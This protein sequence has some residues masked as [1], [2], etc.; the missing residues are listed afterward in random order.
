M[1]QFRLKAAELTLHTQILA[2]VENVDREI[3]KTKAR[4]MDLN[5]E[6]QS[7][8]RMRDEWVQHL[9]TVHNLTDRDSINLEG[10]IGVMDDAYE[11]DTL[12]PIYPV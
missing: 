6:F 4:L 3:T 1:K 7:A 11:T 10:V 5:Y 8:L 12:D 9:Q 2:K